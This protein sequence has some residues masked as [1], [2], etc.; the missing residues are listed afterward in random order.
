MSPQAQQIAIADWCHDH[1][2]SVTTHWHDGNYLTNSNDMREAEKVL[3]EDD[4]NEYVSILINVVFDRTLED[5]REAGI[6]LG[7]RAFFDVVN[8]TASQRAEAFLKTIE[9]WKDS[10]DA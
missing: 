9:K 10:N 4:K 6:A 7:P 8:A 2:D 3:G 5:Q 1:S